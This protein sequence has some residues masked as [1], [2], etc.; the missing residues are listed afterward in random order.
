MSGQHPD[1]AKGLSQ[2]ARI[3]AL[4]AAAGPAGVPNGVLGRTIGF[5]YG[6]RLK[7]LRDAGWEIVSVRDEGARWRYVLRGRKEA[8]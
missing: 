6:A 4:L 5:R 3:L 1:R 2:N 8:A 7:N